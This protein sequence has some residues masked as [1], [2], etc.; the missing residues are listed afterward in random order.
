M[1]FAV[2]GG[3]GVCAWGVDQAEHL[4]RRLV[5]PVL[6]VSHA[7]SGLDLEVPLVSAGDGVGS[8]ALDLVVPSALPI[9]RFSRD[10]Y[11]PLDFGA[12]AS[13]VFK[14]SIE[15]LISGHCQSS[16]RRRKST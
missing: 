2:D 14:P 4:A 13:L 6:Q 16:R 10:G 11:N 9:Q 7:V 1:G 15:E 5:E 3:R 12:A 8:E